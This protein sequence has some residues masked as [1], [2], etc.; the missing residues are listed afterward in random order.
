M[1][2]TEIDR[3]LYKQCLSRAPGAWEDFVDRFIGVIVH[4]IRHTAHARSVPLSSDDVDD[5]C[6][7]VFVALLR[8]DFAILRRFRGECALS[9]YLTVVARRI[10]VKE[11]AR[12]RKAEALGHVVAHQAVAPSQ[13]DGRDHTSEIEDAEEVRRLLGRLPAKDA[14]VVELFH[15][16]NRSYRE[17]SEELAVPEN[18]IGPTLTRARELMKRMSGTA[19]ESATT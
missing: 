18:S 12:R 17:I 14:R 16:H 11:I 2:L 9:T 7:E 3:R 10:V 15:L 6:S 8:D 4:V 19:T 5:L 1:A 13:N